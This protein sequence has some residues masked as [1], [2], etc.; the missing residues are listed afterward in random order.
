MPKITD[1]LI[2]YLYLH[3]FFE[4]DPDIRLWYIPIIVSIN[5][6][7]YFPKISF[8]FLSQFTPE[9]LL[10]LFYFLLSLD[11]FSDHC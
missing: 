5:T 11:A 7:K 6:A 8:I 4:E 3:K 1:I 10:D 2:T 9:P